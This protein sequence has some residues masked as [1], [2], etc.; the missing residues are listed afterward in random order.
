M[1]LD[2]CQQTLKRAVIHLAESRKGLKKSRKTGKT[3]K[4]LRKT[5]KRRKEKG[6]EEER[7]LVPRKPRN[8]ETKKL[9]E[10]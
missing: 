10:I 9:G 7:Q 5:G 3:K 2:I 8:K 4:V 6:G 1:Y